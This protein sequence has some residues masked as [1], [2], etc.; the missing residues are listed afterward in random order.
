MRALD[1]LAAAR[2][3][4]GI[5]VFLGPARLGGRYAQPSS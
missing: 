2:A 1:I 3:L 5:V 4:S